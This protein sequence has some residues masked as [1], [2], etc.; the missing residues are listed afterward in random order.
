MPLAAAALDLLDAAENGSTDAV[1]AL[2]AAQPSLVHVHDSDG[3]TPLHRAAYN[4]HADCC[5]ALL[6]AGA[7]VDARTLDAWTPLHS[8]ARWDAASA[9]HVLLAAGADANA[10]SCSGLTPLH[11]AA[12]HA[13]ERASRVLLADPR[14]DRS[15]RDLHGDT[16]RDIARRKCP[17]S[18]LFDLPPEPH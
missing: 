9:M 5:A 3:Y 17:F 7:A 14:V 1:A 6:A 8:A 12:A 4:D 2:C 10:R 11:I 18:A 13:A 15:V 16:A